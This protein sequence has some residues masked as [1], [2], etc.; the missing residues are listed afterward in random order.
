MQHGTFDN[1][2]IPCMLQN[3]LFLHT[4]FWQEGF[5]NIFNH[6]PDSSFCIIG[7]SNLVNS[8]IFADSCLDDTFTHFGGLLYIFHGSVSSLISLSKDVLLLTPPTIQITLKLL[9]QSCLN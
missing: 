2:D 4:S 6:L 9:D 3:L 7:I 1:F 8:L 5:L